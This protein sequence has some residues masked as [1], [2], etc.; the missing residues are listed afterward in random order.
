MKLNIAN[1]N[2]EVTR[3]Q[4]Q[5]SE[6]NAEINEL[7]ES[8]ASVIAAKEKIA[9]RALEE[10]KRLQQQISEKDE[11]NIGLKGNLDTVTAAKEV[12]AERDLEEI[13]RLK[14]ELSKKNSEMK[15]TKEQLNDVHKS[16][17]EQ[18]D[19]LDAKNKLIK[20]L[21]SQLVGNRQY[22]LRNRSGRKGSC[23]GRHPIKKEGKTEPLYDV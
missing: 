6:Q 13:T 4:K 20:K 1:A 7:K 17:Q 14:T 22:P 16:W 18:V 21:E 10:V 23:G 19:E 9:K 5:L 3:H 12:N 2:Q 8:L 15:M 11:E